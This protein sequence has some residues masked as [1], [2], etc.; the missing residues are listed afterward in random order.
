MEQIVYF[1]GIYVPI[2]EAL[3]PANDIT[4]LRGYGIFDFLRTFNRKPLFGELYLQRFI[5]S[6]RQMEL[7]LLPTLDELK[8]IIEKLILLHPDRELGI[9]LLL[10]GGTA[11][12]AYSIGK[13][14]LVIF[15]EEIHFPT[16]KQYREGV[17]LISHQ[18]QREW[19]RVKTINY[20][21]GIR[22]KGLCRSENAFDVLFYQQDLVTE[23]TRSNFFIVKDGKLI[24]PEDHI[25][26]GVTR[27]KVLQ[28]AEK[29]LPVEVRPLQLSEVYQADE[30]FLT[31]TT[32]KVLPVTTVDHQQ[33][34]KGIPGIFTLQLMEG[35][36]ELETGN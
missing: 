20:L 4:L 2:K 25:L 21:T 15:A 9:R 23:V 24:T 6:A 26:L 16:E 8:A 10:T 22:L 3:I 11:P 27:N 33:I 19:P 30:A 7:P 1:N 12:D 17:K 5:E 35:F 32:K 34:G 36:R 28:L 18:Y 29:M 13:S 14:S 31:G